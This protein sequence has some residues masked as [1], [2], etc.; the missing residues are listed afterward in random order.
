MGMRGA[1]LLGKG[2]RLSNE[3]LCQTIIYAK[4]STEA[5]GT[6]PWWYDIAA[7]ETTPR[8]TGGQAP[9]ERAILPA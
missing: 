5:Q 1:V 8:V 6:N 9:P 4:H 7:T 3:Y 2:S